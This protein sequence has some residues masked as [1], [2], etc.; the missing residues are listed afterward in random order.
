MKV[1][2]VVPYSWSFWGGV[3]EHAEL[4]AEA[5][6][7]LGLETR[8]LIGNDPPGNFTR[9]LHPRH[10]RHDEPPADV[11]PVGRSVIVPANR[12]LPNI[13][14]SPRSLF[15]I[16]RILERE[17][18]RR[19]P[20]A[21]ADDADPVHRGA[22]AV[23]R[24]DRRDLARVRRPRLAAAREP[25]VGLPRRPDRPSH[26]RLPESARVGGALPPGRV[27]DPPE[28]RPDPAARRAGRARAP[29]R[30]RGPPRPP[31]G[32]SGASA[33]VA[34]DPPPHRRDPPDRGRRPALRPAAARARPDRRR[35]D[36][37]PRLPEPGRPDRRAAVGEGARRAVARR[38]ELRHGADARVRVRD[39]CRRVGH[40]RVHGRHDARNRSAGAARR[41]RRA[42]G[43]GRPSCSL[44]RSAGR[45]SAQPPGGS[46]SSATPGMRSRGGCS[47]STRA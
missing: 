31:Q 20:P 18:L 29:H 27:R 16:R 22:R 39:A 33:R 34:R 10:G 28:R 35:R 23:G 26:R 13:I 45:S 24:P 1:G 42:R 7:R 15:R 12:S 47:R 4:Q 37:D 25:D 14:L 5:L 19:P 43:R 17:R 6:R 8:T 30:L 36:R 21:R 2:I 44:T 3:V 40:R 32:A 9:A 46:R 41:P 11:L 38:R